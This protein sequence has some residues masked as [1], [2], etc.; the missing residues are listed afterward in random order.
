MYSIT[1]IRITLLLALASIAVNLFAQDIV[2]Y[3]A[4]LAKYCTNSKQMASDQQRD[5]LTSYKSRIADI[6]NADKEATKNL[7]EV[8]KQLDARP[9]LDFFDIAPEAELDYSLPSTLTLMKVYI[10]GDKVDGAAFADYL[11][12]ARD[13]LSEDWIPVLK[14]YIAT[15]NVN[16]KIY[17]KMLVLL[18]YMGE[19]RIQVAPMLNTMAKT[20]GDVN[21]LKTL[22]Y[23]KDFK[24]GELIPEINFNNTTIM[25]E[26]A[27]SANPEML[28]VSAEYALKIN[29]IATA[30]KAYAK[31]FNMPYPVGKDA[32]S[33][34]TGQKQQQARSEALR[35]MLYNMSNEWAF[36]TALAL[37]FTDTLPE[38]AKTVADANP[39]V[40]FPDDLKKNSFGSSD[41][42]IAKGYLNQILE[43]K[44]KTE[45]LPK[46][47]AAETVVTPPKN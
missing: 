41:V 16:M 31:L 17:N 26:L 42:A 36:R 35:V 20:D 28:M 27:G 45:E 4:K 25:R 1:I 9:K 23:K 34:A 21:A 47:P 12:N 19:N 8:K 15:K 10:M 14:E 43:Y 6:A 29:D 24:T 44:P 2:L 39:T 46:V 33:A 37:T 30:E 13:S 18:A 5:A 38:I 3:D 7:A 22:F 40:T 11:F 32:K